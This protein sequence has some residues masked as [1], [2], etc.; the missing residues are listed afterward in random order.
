MAHDLQAS[1]VA[2]VIPSHKTVLD[3]LEIVAVRRAAEVLGRYDL[4][5]AVPA[6]MDDTR[7]R[8]WLPAFQV[9]R[10]D[11]YYFSTPRAYNHLCRVADFYSRFERY[12]YILLHQTDS[13]VFR[14]ELLE[15]CGRGYD[16]I[17]APWPNYECQARSRKRWV[18]S[19]L[20]RPFLR[21]VGNGGFSLRR[22]EKMRD[23]C[24]TLRWWARNMLDFPEDVFWSN[25]ASRLAGLRI[26]DLRVALRFAFDDSPERCLALNQGQLPF[27]CHAW[28]TTHLDFWRKYIPCRQ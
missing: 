26:P 23:A 2:V 9:A 13:Y 16:Y 4:W 21:K 17:G 11:D 27:G 6:T 1:D 18:R 5:I 22:V 10:F 19:R 3:P 7:W 14:D 12:K 20:L 28:N 8:Q 25:I 15:W 24:N